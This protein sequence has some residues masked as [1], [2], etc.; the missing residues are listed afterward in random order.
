[1]T[2]HHR[3]PLT[4]EPSATASLRIG[5]VYDRIEDYVIDCGPADR[6]AEFEPESTIRAM[7][8][9]IQLAGHLPVRIG[10]PVRLLEKHPDVDLIWNIGEG[11]GTRN[12]EAWAPILCEMHGIPCLGSD[13]YALTITLDKVLTKQIARNLGISTSDWQVIPFPGGQA[14][15]NHNSNTDHQP[16]SVSVPIPAP[17]LP[18]PQF[19][20][21]RY[22]GTSKGITEKSIVHTPDE[23]RS[24]CRHLLETYHQDVMAEPFLGGAELTCALAFHPLQAFPVMERGLHSSG[25]G[26]HAVDN[27]HH[28][29]SLSGSTPHKTDNRITAGSGPDAETFLTCAITPEL[30][31]DITK[32]SLLLCSEF[33][34]R[35][36]VRI[37]FKLT[38]DGK[39]MF[40]EAN[41]LP[42]FGTDSTFAILAEI[43]DEPY[44]V[45]LSGI[46]SAAIRRLNM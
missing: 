44:P 11:Y 9:A 8:E 7:E 43:R 31:A 3:H 22:E 40:L 20:K 32:W 35:D 27:S 5:I 38:G 25:I 21:P 36:F 23:F 19:L 34:I 16:E 29:Q 4:A 24:Q 41:P 18:F 13:A 12:R 15:A 46:L 30:E 28:L 26:S 33:G 17:I 10:S 39:P 2:P 37:D 1:M 42:T 45:L 14:G 6:F